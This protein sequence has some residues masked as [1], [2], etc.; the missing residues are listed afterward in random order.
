MREQR[1]INKD[2]REKK[3]GHSSFVIW[4]TGLSGAGK[5][6]LAAMAEKYLFSKNLN[7]YVLDG[8]N[9]RLGLNR[10]L[11]FSKADRKE[12]IRRVAEVAALFCD[13]GMITITAFISPYT[14][15][16]EIA[17]AI[18]GENRFVEVFVNA[19]LECCRQRDVKGLYKK[20]EAG[21][22]KSFT[23]IDDVYEVPLTPDVVLH[24]DK[25]TAELSLDKLISWLTQKQMI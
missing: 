1:Y 6:T 15:D 12:N 8:D 16:R 18:I 24:T 9:I 11:G 22:I 21:L 5:S 25:E 4:L 7:V 10:D 20:A 3:N 2:E 19:P 23:G 13:A 14:E 17:K